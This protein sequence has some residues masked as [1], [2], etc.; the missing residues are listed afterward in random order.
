MSVFSCM[1]IYVLLCV[2]NKDQSINQSIN[3]SAIA[4][5]KSYSMSLGRTNQT[6]QCTTNEI[7][8]LHVTSCLDLGI[9]VRNDLA[10]TY[11]INN[12]AGKSPQ[13]S[14]LDTQMLCLS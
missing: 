5:G 2:R 1:Y 13:A 4:V 9:T 6:I 11:R 14:K 10:P 8:L 12:I 7:P 3:Q